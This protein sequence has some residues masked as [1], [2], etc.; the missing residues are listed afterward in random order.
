MGRKKIY[1]EEELKKR[2]SK[3][4]HERYLK[5]KEDEEY[6]KRKSENAKKY[7]AK[8]PDKIKDNHKKFRDNNP[9]YNKRYNEIWRKTKKGRANNLLWG[10][11]ENDK[12]A[13]RGKCTLTS[14]WI[15]ENIFS[16]QKCVYCGEDD[17]T[18]LGCDR[19]YNDKPHT[20]DNVVCCC[21]ECNVKK[22][23]QTYDEFIKL[24]KVG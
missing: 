18:K 24:N 9:E 7:R 13:N 20:P 17:W 19:I 14:K 1:T 2:K 8:N 12:K 22:H 15:V 23:L 4:N 10:Y 16:G 5:I 6:K 11:K 21:T 3:R